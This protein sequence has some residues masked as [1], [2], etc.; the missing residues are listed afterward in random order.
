MASTLAT[1]Q[2]V[3]AGGSS[4]TVG[5]SLGATSVV[6]TNT[7]TPFLASLQ[8]L[9]V[10]ADTVTLGAG[11]SVTLPAA[12]LLAAQPGLTDCAVT[13]SV[14]S[15]TPR[16]EHVAVQL[17]LLP[18]GVTGQLMPP[19]CSVA[20]GVPLMSPPVVMANTSTPLVA[21]LQTLSEAALT[22]RDGG[23]T[24]GAVNVTLVLAAQATG[25]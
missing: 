8:T 19:G 21:P 3:G 5:S 16:P 9:S 12:V 14:Y 15:F 23:V 11:A 17:V 18:A 6:M 20:T 25:R 24:L 7:S 2:S 1:T 10:G 4:T 13:L 22:S